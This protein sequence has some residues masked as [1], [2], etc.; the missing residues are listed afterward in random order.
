MA[1]LYAEALWDVYNSSYGYGIIQEGQ[2]YRMVK[3]ATFASKEL[4]YKYVF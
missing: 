3:G 4:V 2:G 1:A